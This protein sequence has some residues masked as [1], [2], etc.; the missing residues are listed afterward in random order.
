MDLF[1]GISTF[2]SATG[3]GFVISSEGFTVSYILLASISFLNLLFTKSIVEETIAVDT[4]TKA[5]FLSSLDMKA[6]IVVYITSRNGRWQLTILL[7][8]MIICGLSDIF[9][10]DTVTYHLLDK[11]QCFTPGLIGLYTGINEIGGTICVVLLQRKLGDL[12]LLLLGICSLLV[13]QALLLAFH[14]KTTLF[15]GEKTE[16]LF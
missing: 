9:A 12:G 13:Y 2:L 10:G 4:A 7:I 5:N 3:F 11:P 16:Y 15:T 6:S 8:I 1:L 14:S